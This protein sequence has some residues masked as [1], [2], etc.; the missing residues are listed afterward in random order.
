M[1][2]VAVV[3]ASGYAGIELT[4]ILAGHP[5]LRLV[6]VTSHA[7][8]G[9]L[10]SE[11]YPKL[12]SVTDLRYE[13]PEISLLL[14]RAQVV[15]LAVPHTVSMEIVPK[16]HKAGII[17]ID[18][19]ADYRLKNPENYKYW[20]GAKHS[21]PELLDCAVYGLPE[22]D[23]SQ[24]PGAR[25]VACPGC[26]PTATILA[27]APALQAGIVSGNRVIVDAKSGVSGAGKEAS[28]MTHFPAVNETV[29]AYK[30]ASHRHIPEMEQ[31]LSLL[32]HR[33]IRVAFTPHLVPMTRGLLSTVYMELT[34]PMTTAEVWGMYADRYGEEPY[35]TIC[36]P[37]KMPSTG[38]VS[39]TNRAHIGLAC[40]PSGVLIVTCAIDN[41]I[42]GTSGQAVQC[43]NL[44]L[45]IEETAGLSMSAPVI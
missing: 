45:G 27:A 32:A 29:S 6:M 40:D 33:Q 31:Q 11:V 42:K 30:V 23:R 26:Y 19:S 38:E 28:A 44:V 25:L 35:I 5:D 36:E 39:G 8:E 1:V 2:D 43:A 21:S 24:L 22:I 34:K 20:Y 4:R 16:L 18:A 10:V 12:T 3:G 37:G 41:L 13:A 9:R 7:E 17:I 14:K 15:F